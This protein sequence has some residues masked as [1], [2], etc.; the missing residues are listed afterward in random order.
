MAHYYREDAVNL[1]P[2]E[3][4]AREE[5]ISVMG[6]VARLVQEFDGKILNKRLDTALKKISPHLYL[7]TSYNSFIIRYSVRHFSTKMAHSEYGVVRLYD[8]NKVICHCCKYSAGDD[9]CV[10]SENRIIAA[11]IV[12]T[13]NKNAAYMDE[14]IIE[15]QTKISEIERYCE[16]ITKIEEELR[17]LQNEIP[18]AIKEYFDLHRRI[19]K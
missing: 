15:I 12:A 9:S 4:A 6:E 2:L 11:P 1:I 16:S 19:T 14:G 3:I 17:S 5:V 7:D 10:S 18:F 8:D 13:I